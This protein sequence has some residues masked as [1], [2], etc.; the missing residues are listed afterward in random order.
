MYFHLCTL[1][2][3]CPQY[4]SGP[5]QPS[6]T[7]GGTCLLTNEPTFWGRKT[8]GEEWRKKTM[9]T[10]GNWITLLFVCRCSPSSHGLLLD[11]NQNGDNPDNWQ[12]KTCERSERKWASHWLYKL[13]KKWLYPSLTFYHSVFSL[14]I[15]K[16]ECY[17]YPTHWIFGIGLLM[18]HSWQIY[19]KKALTTLLIPAC[20]SLV[21]SIHFTALQWLIFEPFW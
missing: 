16:T 5:T 12:L 10:S 20:E 14:L 3:R 4:F 17:T 8:E 13:Y 2:P 18:E 1:K 9:C 11:A 19:S 15:R 6:S 7:P 21:I